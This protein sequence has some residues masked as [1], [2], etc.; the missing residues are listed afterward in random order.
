MVTTARKGKYKG[1]KVLL[2]GTK[3]PVTK[4]KRTSCNRVTSAISYGVMHGDLKKLRKAGLG[5]YVKSC[6][7]ESKYFS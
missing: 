2:Y 4:N 7:I 3:Y 5:K 6:G 1:E